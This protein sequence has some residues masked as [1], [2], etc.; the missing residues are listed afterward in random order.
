MPAT[1]K[2][3][4]RAVPTNRAKSPTNRSEPSSDFMA[5]LGKARKEIEPKSSRESEKPAEPETPEASKTTAKRKAAE[6]RERR[7]KEQ[8]DTVEAPDARKPAP[9]ADGEEAAPVEDVESAVESEGEA[10]DV[11][12]TE[13]TESD[14]PNV[15]AAQLAVAATAKPAEAAG[16]APVEAVEG[17]VESLLDDDALAAILPDAPEGAESPDAEAGAATDGI[18]LPEGLDPA[19]GDEVPVDAV[20]PL[21]ERRPRGTRASADETTTDEL[22]VEAAAQLPAI[23]DGAEAGVAKGAS[24]ATAAAAIDSK[25]AADADLFNGMMNLAS[26][27]PTAPTADSKAV[28]PA[29]Q[30]PPELAFA[31]ANHEKI[32]TSVQ[33][34]ALTNG[35]SMQIRLDPPH[36]GPLQVSVHMRDG[37]MTASFE[38]QNDEATR[39]LSHSLSQLKTTLETQ[40]ITVEKLQVQQAPKS[41]DTNS[42][43]NDPRNPDQQQG[44]REGLSEQQ[45]Q[46]Q[47]QEMLKRMWSR[48]QGDPIDLMA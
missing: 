36:L 6:A 38:T 47:R 46:K 35:G 10:T 15:A 30:L 43:S 45:Q 20:K 28:A 48:L 1:L 11:N 17:D 24:H 25:L 22:A 19:N 34:Q 31:R 8:D 3:E 13:E 23:A 12:E 7:Q 4:P 37:V 41:Q 5:E 40:G 32:V 29:Q 26:P 2:V 21:T 44:A 16:D 18:A 27:Q 42:N 33:G 39:L 9:K 14:D